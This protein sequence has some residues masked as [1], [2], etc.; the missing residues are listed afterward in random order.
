MLGS[1]IVILTQFFDPFLQQAVVY[2]DRLVPSEVSPIIVR[3]DRYEARSLEGLPIPSIIDLSMKAAIYRGVFNMRDRAEQDLVHTCPTGNCTWSSFTTLAACNRCDD[4]TNKIEKVCDNN[5][6]CVLS[7]PNGPM[8]SGYG[9]QINSSITNISSSLKEIQPSIFKFSS[10]KSQ[11]VDGSDHA[12][13]MECAMWYCVNTYTATVVD[14][15]LTEDILSSWRND[16]ATPSLSSDLIYHPPISSTNSTTNF[17][18]FRVAHLAATSMNNFVSRLFTGSGEVNSSGSMFTSDTIQ[19]LYGTDNLTAL[20]DHLAI[21]ITNNIR[22][23]ND[24]VSSSNWRGTA[25]TSQ[26]YVHVRW[27]WIAFPVILVVLSSALLLGTIT[28]T[29]YR[30]VMVWKSDNLALLFHGRGL[31]LDSLDDTPVNKLSEMTEKAKEIRVELT[32]GPSKA[33]NFVERL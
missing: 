2:P 13:A 15:V 31:E 9:D 14:G 29:K 18:D 19:A 8:L 22:Q 7:L 5:E 33:W 6:S 24:S 28:E 10:L 11:K 26:T 3:T 1:I 25:W 20:I 17:S 23:Q 21:A 16:S 4:I 27:G 12:S 32:Q 30:D